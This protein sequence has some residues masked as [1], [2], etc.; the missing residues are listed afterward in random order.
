MSTPL[1][2]MDESI[3]GHPSSPHVY[4]Y[5]TLTLFS[6]FFLPSHPSFL[7]FSFPNQKVV[8]ISAR[9]IGLLLPTKLS[10]GKVWFLILVGLD[11]VLFV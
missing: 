7:F 5:D 11:V 10:R 2:E 4:M 6:F 3:S 1:N 9:S 8:Y